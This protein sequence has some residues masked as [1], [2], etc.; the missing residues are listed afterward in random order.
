MG[1]VRGTDPARPRSIKP[2]HIL[3]ANVDAM[4]ADAQ[5]NDKK[6]RTGS[7][8]NICVSSKWMKAKSVDFRGHF[9]STFFFFMMINRD[10][11]SSSRF[12]SPTNRTE[13]LQETMTDAL[14]LCDGFYTLNVR[15]E[16]G[17]VLQTDRSVTNCRSV[18]NIWNTFKSTIISVWPAW[19]PWWK[20]CLQS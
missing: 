10:D 20:Q 6:K 9:S 11:D 19:S 4:C 7:S 16:R 15:P 12:L 2:V 8:G 17:S 5:W 3:W 14:T 1:V 18:K 13:M